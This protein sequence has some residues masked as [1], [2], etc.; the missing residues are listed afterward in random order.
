MANRS[1]RRPCGSSPRRKGAATADPLRRHAPYLVAAALLL[2]ACGGP[3]A[4]RAADGWP[5]GGPRAGSA[6]S[7]SL[8]AGETHR[9]PLDLAAGTYLR[10]AVEQQDAD[11]AVVLVAPDGREVVA[12]EPFER[13]GAELLPALA[14]VGGR[15]E[16]VVA[17]SESV[18]AGGYEL[19]VEALGPASA[20]D[21]ANADAYAVHREARRLRDAEPSRA[22]TLWRQA[23]GEWRRLGEAALEA[24]ALA[25]LGG[26]HCRLGE[27][28]PAAGAYRRSA[29]AFERGGEP[30]LAAFALNNAALCRFD[31]GQREAAPGRTGLRR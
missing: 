12:D 30:R 31:N 7:G 8:A 20:A 28:E 1:A 4:E 17:N 2:S 6:L 18:Q 25:R 5:A 26:L 11:L 16:I 19:R 29:A 13:S 23:A 14:T 15:H 9:H 10:L 3:G 27:V 21:R 24:R 22:L